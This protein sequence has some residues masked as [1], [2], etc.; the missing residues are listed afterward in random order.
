MTPQDLVGSATARQPVPMIAEISLLT[1]V[2]ALELWELWQRTGRDEPPFWAYP[3]AGGQ[4]LA[5]YLLDHPH[6]VAGRRVL[7]VASGSGLVAIA[8]A[9]AGAASVVAGDIDPHAVAAIA[10]NAS[11]N[12]VAVEARVFDL[13]ADGPGDAEL[14]LAGDVFYQRELAG[15]ALRFLRAAGAAGADVLVADPGRAFVPSEALTALARFEVPVLTTIE[16]A[17]VKSVTVYR[18]G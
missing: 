6:V 18:L 14:V 12:G 16:D 11:A 3:W 4:A 2:P 1:A 17:P 9:Q 7:D 5:R 10:I 15:L 13:A 8:A